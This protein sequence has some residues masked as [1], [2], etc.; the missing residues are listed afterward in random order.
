MGVRWVALAAAVG[1]TGLLVACSDGST[2]TVEPPDGCPDEDLFEAEACDETYCGDPVVSV[3]VGGSSHEPVDDGQTVPVW[4]GSQGGFHINIS[5]ETENLC[6][7]VFLR[8]AMD[9]RDPGTDEWTEVFQQERHVQA[10]RPAVD[11][12]MQQYWGIQGFVPC[13]YWPEYISESNPDE[14]VNCGETTSTMGHIDDK[15]VRIRLEAE[16]HNGRIGNT[17]VEVDPECC[18]T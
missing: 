4:F 9:V 14:P 6:P 1:A 7:V 5:V 18:S 17:E 16:D 2:G 10:V 11:D 15:E 13:E 3:G 12:S 8:A